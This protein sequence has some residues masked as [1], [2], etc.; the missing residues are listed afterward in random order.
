M[1]LQICYAQIVLH[2]AFWKYEYHRC[3]LISNTI[4]ISLA[5]RNHRT[6][7][8]L[9]TPTLEDAEPGRTSTSL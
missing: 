5:K 3:S 6:G 8:G 4:D 1:S 9:A 2:G 7:N